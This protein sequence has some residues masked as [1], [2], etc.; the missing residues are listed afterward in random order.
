MTASTW[1]RLSAAA[2]LSLQALRENLLLP[3]REQH[4][5]LLEDLFGG[6]GGGIIGTSAASLT[7]SS[8]TLTLA[9]DRE[10]VTGSGYRLLL[11]ASDAAWTSI[12]FANS[13]ATTYY[14]GAQAQDRPTR[15]LAGLGGVLS[16]EADVEDIG[17]LGAP[18]LVT[19]N[20]DGT[21]TLRLNSLVAPVWSVGGTRPVVV[22]LVTPVTAGLEAVYE[23]TCSASGGNVVVTVPH[24]LGQTA[25]ST[26]A[27]DYR[28]LV[29]GPRITTTN[30]ATNPDYCYLGSV[31][32]GAFS[33]TSQVMFRPFYALFDVE[34]DTANGVHNRVTINGADDGLE[35]LDNGW[36]LV[37]GTGSI[38]VLTGD[39][40]VDTGDVVLTQGSV[41]ADPTAASV[42]GYRYASAVTFSEDF[43]PV[44]GGWTVTSGAFAWASGTPSYVQ[45]ASNT[46][47]VV[48]RRPI[49]TWPCADHTAAPTLTTVVYRYIRAAVADTV[50]VALKRQ[51]RD[52]TGAED[53]V[54]SS[55]GGVTGT[56]AT[57]TLTLNH[58]VSPLY[59][60]WLEISIDPSTAA[61]D[62]RVADV[63]VSVTKVAVE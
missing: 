32:S 31:T 41:V 53:T 62:A 60:Y 30:I 33:G 12:P 36:I 20:G 45:S 8:S 13:G 25:V 59:A 44:R 23:G 42:A 46:D 14:I 39:V 5:Q 4:R 10:A 15:A 51:K 19:N 11:D 2:I 48:A 1:H 52:G 3:T 43:A 17:T 9:A 16:Y 28:V 49:V 27:A 58:V 18:D 37:G 57:A 7:Y 61:A 38:E 55:I 22:W 24:L 26:T 35:I 56:F 40:L 21:L 29:R 47:P 6:A 50:T 34:H 63:I 54:G